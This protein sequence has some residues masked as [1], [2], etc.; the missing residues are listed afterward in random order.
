MELPPEVQGHL[1]PVSG[2][3]DDFRLV[4]LPLART[5]SPVSGLRRFA[6]PPIV[7]TTVPDPAIAVRCTRLTT[8]LWSEVASGVPLAT[9]LSL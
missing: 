5:K 6:R 2:R 7:C 8:V 1:A 3:S 4:R 9:T